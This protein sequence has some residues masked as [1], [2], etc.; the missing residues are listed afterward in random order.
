M[1]EIAAEIIQ[2]SLPAVQCY[3]SS[4]IQRH[5]EFIHTFQEKGKNPKYLNEFYGFPVVTRQEKELLVPFPTALTRDR[6]SS[7]VAEYSFSH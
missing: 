2:N 6:Q 4:R 1:V 5:L 3:S 7:F